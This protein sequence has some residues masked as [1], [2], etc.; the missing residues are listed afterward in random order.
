MVKLHI[1]TDVLFTGMVISCLIQLVLNSSVATHI[2][3]HV[4]FT[5]IYAMQS[6]L[7][8]GFKMHHDSIKM[9]TIYAKHEVLK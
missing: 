1:V 6:I 9:L 2:V 4:L 5:G 8:S 3:T 7:V